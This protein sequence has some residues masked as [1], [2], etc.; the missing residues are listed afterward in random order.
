M[1]VFTVQ[2]SHL[3]VLL[4]QHLLED[5][6]N[7][8]FKD[9]IVAVRHQKV[10]NPASM[11]DRKFTKFQKSVPRSF[12]YVSPIQAFFIQILAR[13]RELPQVK[14]AQTL[15]QVLLDASSCGH[16]HVNLDKK[17]EKCDK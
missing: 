1:Q 6:H 2:R 9:D 14:K 5:W 15:D 16:Q 3:S 11:A 17:G 4:Q 10:S 7:P 12:Y 8:L 13:Q